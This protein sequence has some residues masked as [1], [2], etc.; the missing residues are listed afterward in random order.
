MLHED[1]EMEMTRHELRPRIEDRDDRL[2][3]P[4][5]RRELHL[6]GTRTVAEA[7]Q[8]IRPELTVGTELVGS[9]TNSS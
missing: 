6:P 1:F 4:V 7:A 5:R 8:I 9:D 2:P 3:L